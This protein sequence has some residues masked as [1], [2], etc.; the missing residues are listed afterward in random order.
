MLYLQVNGCNET[1][2][3]TGQNLDFLPAHT[4]NQQSCLQEISVR[5]MMYETCSHL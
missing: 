3:T 2:P 1:P 5:H 4:R